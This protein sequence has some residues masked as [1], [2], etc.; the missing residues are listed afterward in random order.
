MTTS[1]EEKTEY[2]TLRNRLTKDG[3][4]VAFRETAQHSYAEEDLDRLTYLDKDG[5]IKFCSPEHEK[6]INNSAFSN[7]LSKLAGHKASNPNYDKYITLSDHLT[8]GG[9]KQ[10]LLETAQYSYDRRD[11]NR[12]GYK[13]ENGHF[14]FIDEQHEK[15]VLESR[16]QKLGNNP[17]QDQS[18]SK[19]V[20]KDAKQK[21]LSNASNGM[22][23]AKEIAGSL[24]NK[25]SGVSDDG[26]EIGGASASTAAARGLDKAMRMSF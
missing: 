16:K 8:D 10:G 24:A 9:K 23:K 5:N 21:D 11:L 4:Q 22:D 6:D 3:T 2:K 15:D 18:Q 25:I 20:G 12:L 26:K 13:D 1:S 17:E 14:H 7:A 19:E